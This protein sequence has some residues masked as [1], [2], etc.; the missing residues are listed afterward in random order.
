[1]R[2]ILLLQ[3]LTAMLV[4]AALA[5]TLLSAC[6]DKKN[7]KLSYQQRVDALTGSLNFGDE[8]SYLSCFLPQYKTLFEA[9]E[10]AGDNANGDT[11][12]E[13][14]AN[15]D[16]DSGYTADVQVFSVKTVFDRAQYS[17]R[18]AAKMLDDKPLN[19]GELDE[20]EKQMTE[21]IGMRA[22]FSKGRRTSVRF[23][24]RS[25]NEIISAT[26]EVLLV[27]YENMWYIYGD[28]IAEPLIEEG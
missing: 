19:D 15:G 10:A 25:G 12:D 27:R 1:M 16:N 26:R 11:A 18:L 3:Q 22:E 21:Q 7:E 13:D 24:A 20:L 2:R 17:G 9:A 8:Q 5:C 4:C 14:T 23:S 28:V 6:S